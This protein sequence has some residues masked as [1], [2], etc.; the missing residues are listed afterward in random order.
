VSEP[1][2][3]TPCPYCCFADCEADWVDVGV[4][5]IQCGPYYCPDCGASEIG[6]FDPDRDDAHTADAKRT[7]WYPPGAPLSALANAIGGIPV[8]HQTAKAVY[9]LECD[10]GIRILDPKPERQP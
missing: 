7:G 6:P 8:D 5:Y 4:G 3:K 1:F 2:S 10:L 9:E